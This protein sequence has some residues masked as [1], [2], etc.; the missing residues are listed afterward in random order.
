M[1]KMLFF[2][3]TLIPIAMAEPTTAQ[4]AAV[5]SQVIGQRAI[6]IPGTGYDL[7]LG[8]TEFRQS[9]ASSGQALL[10]AI[11]TWLSIQFDLPIIDT[12]PR[13]AL[14]PVAKIVALRFGS[15]LSEKPTASGYDRGTGE[16]DIVAVYHN[17][18]QTIYLP[19]TWT[20]GTPAELSVLI[21]EMVHHFQKVLDLKYECPQERERLAYAA[22]DRWLGLFGQNLA[23]DFGLD[24]FSLLVKTKCFY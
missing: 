19:E 18:T 10:A 12:H 11:E 2:L 4:E 8:S 7:I 1:F 16:S 9:N 15:F 3:A 14:V 20:G 5:R 13:I 6:T 23:D 24:P 22:Q 17:P 21:H